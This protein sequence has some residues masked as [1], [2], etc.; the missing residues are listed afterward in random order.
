MQ[1]APV[2]L[3]SAL[4]CVAAASSSSVP[5]SVTLF[6]IY[7]E[8]G[9]S[10]SETIADVLWGQHSSLAAA[11]SDFV[12]ITGR[13]IA[14]SGSDPNDPSD[15]IVSPA[16]SSFSSASRD[17][18][19]TFI[20]NYRTADS[21]HRVF[22]RQAKWTLLQQES[23]DDTDSNSTSV[24]ARFAE[25]N[26]ASATVCVVLSDWDPSWNQNSQ[27]SESG[28]LAV[29]LVTDLLSHCS[30]DD[31]VAFGLTAAVSSAVT[32]YLEGSALV[33]DALSPLPMAETVN[34][35][36]QQQITDP[37]LSIDL[38]NIPV[39]ASSRLFVHLASGMCVDQAWTALGSDEA[40][41]LGALVLQ[42]C[43]GSACNSC[44]PSPSSSSSSGSSS[45][46]ST[47]NSTGSG[48]ATSEQN[49][50]IVACCLVFLLGSSCLYYQ[51]FGRKRALTLR[52]SDTSK[53]EKEI[54]TN[55]A[56]VLRV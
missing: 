10:S 23:S 37:I 12:L 40:G 35:L 2:L 6:N 3:L 26:D 21:H 52:S 39:A 25:L 9:D 44:T 16:T 20:E 4:H 19:A 17:E 38:N 43:H 34:L 22:F 50:V 32:E 5:D 56:Y 1:I 46:E 45:S 33:D 49:V 30:S 31:V 36:S 14:S 13:A 48:L 18:V 29:R 54:A 8:A 53:A 47:V 15:S 28:Q 11:Q 41:A 42:F 55:L 51:V 27:A 24:W 7:S